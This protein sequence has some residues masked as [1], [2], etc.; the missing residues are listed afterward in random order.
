MNMLKYA[1]IA[2]LASAYRPPSGS[3]PWHAD[4]HAIAASGWPFEKGDPS[5]INY[6]VPNF[7]NDRDM[8]NTD[9][10]IKWAEAKTKKKWKVPTKKEL[11]KKDY[12]KD[13]FVPNFGLDKDIVDTQNIIANMEKKY[14]KWTPKQDDNGV[15]I[16]PSAADNKSYSYKK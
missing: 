7:G 5:K 2:G 12:P 10:S 13:Y 6:F 16:V 4:A 15:W 3:N 14:G 1:L 11:K 9:N 8:I